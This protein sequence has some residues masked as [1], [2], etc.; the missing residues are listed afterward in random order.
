MS[1][2]AGMKWPKCETGWMWPQMGGDKPETAPGE[3][4]TTKGAELTGHGMCATA[5]EALG[6]FPIGDL[7]PWLPRQL[8][9]DIYEHTPE[10]A[11]CP[12]AAHDSPGLP[13]RHMLP[14]NLARWAGCT[15]REAAQLADVCVALDAT[16]QMAREF[17]RWARV[18][19][20]AATLK[21]LEPLAT[22]AVQAEGTVGDE[23]AMPAGGP[24]DGYIAETLAYHR[25]G[26][27]DENAADWVERH[28]ESAALWE[29]AKAENDPAAVAAA[30]KRLYEAGHEFGTPAERSFAWAVLTAAAARLRRRAEKAKP[31]MARALQARIAAAKTKAELGAAGRALYNLQ[32]GRAQT[33][34]NLAPYWNEL[35][36]AYKAR[37]ETMREEQAAAV[38]WLRRVDEICEP[39]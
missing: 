25:V 10:G 6:G 32:H 31:H 36:Q 12:M 38:A 4:R 1:G 3:C 28:P 34:V 7:R 26:E 22:A 19:G 35:W 20:I 5:T 18:R 33:T 13:A 15:I 29:R 16:E 27:E 39:L 30:R 17:S 24:N 8:E 37:K 14:V 21:Y 23:D 9:R 11:S 2:Q